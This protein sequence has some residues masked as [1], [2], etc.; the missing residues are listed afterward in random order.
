MDYGKAIITTLGLQEVDLLD[1]KIFQKDLRIEATVVQRRDQGSR[2]IRCNGELGN[3]HEW[4]FKI[5]K[6]PPMGVFSDVKIKLKTF[7]AKCSGCKK[8]RSC[9]TD[10][11]YPKHRSMTC[12]FV[13][14]SGRLMEEVSCEAT[15]RLLHSSSMQMFRVDQ[16][17]N[18]FL[19]QYYKIPNTDYDSLGADE[20]H[21]RSEQIKNRKT[22]WSKRWDQKWITNLVDI[23]QGK[24]LFNASGRN[25]KALRDCFSVLSPGQ[26]MAVEYFASD[27]HDPFISEAKRQLPNAK[28]CVDRFH[29]VQ[30]ANRAFDQVRKEELKKAQEQFEK[31]IL[32][33][34]QR[35][36][37]VARD[38]S[39]LTNTEQKW[40]EKLRGINRAIDYGMLLVDYLHQSLDQIT[41]ADFRKSL[42]EWYILVRQ[43][44]LKP[45]RK[46]AKT[47][48]SYRLHLENYIESRLTTATCEGLNNKI[49]TLKRMGYGYKNQTYFRHKILQRCG[50]LNSSSISTDH[51]LF[52]VTN[53]VKC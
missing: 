24:V 1:Y 10:W 27:M 50:F 15:A 35:F 5:I 29:V 34:R 28:L 51:L 46:F 36:I 18:R 22:A 19:L 17:R 38:K 12:G 52:K 30:G 9:K 39:N 3:L 31:E 32:S 40:I 2:C 41:K 21:F 43:S 4:Y 8:N 44:G 14:V 11:I 53:P 13:E 16:T 25:S 49:K 47:I 26:K 42:F 48:R 6:G 45:F 33:G 20:V 23:K 37:L 7:R